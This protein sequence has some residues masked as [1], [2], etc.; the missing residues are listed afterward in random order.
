MYSLLPLVM[1]YMGDGQI[2][3]GCSIGLGQVMVEVCRAESACARAT[4]A[5]LGPRVPQELAGKD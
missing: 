4:A 1:G 5:W 3:R 2:A